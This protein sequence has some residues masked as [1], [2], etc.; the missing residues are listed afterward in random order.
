[1]SV[2]FYQILWIAFVAI[3]A[4]FYISGNLTPVVGVVFGFIIF[5]LVFMGMMSVLPTSIVH[6][7]SE[8]ARLGAAMRTR[9][10]VK[11]DNGMKRFHDWRNTWMSS[12]SIEV[13]RPKFH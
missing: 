3:V 4:A 6:P 11:Y 10:R 2:R 13:R 1:M 7:V 12:G 8:D 5:G 9:L